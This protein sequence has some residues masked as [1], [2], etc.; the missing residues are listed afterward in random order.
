MFSFFILLGVFW[1]FN[2]SKFPKKLIEVP[3][4]IA[5]LSRWFLELL[6]CFLFIDLY[7]FPHYH[8]LRIIQE[9]HGNLSDKYYLFIFRLS[10]NPTVSKIWDHQTPKQVNL[11]FCWEFLP[12]HNLHLRAFFME[13][14]K[15]VLGYLRNLIIFEESKI[16]SNS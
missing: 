5:I 14:P 12:Q 2:Y 9:N 11:C 8:F 10:G 3:G 16:I 13:F 6:K 1:V 15:Y 4:P 7:T